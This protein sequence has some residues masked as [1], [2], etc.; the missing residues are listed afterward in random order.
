MLPIYKK[1]IHVLN[2]LPLRILSSSLQICEFDSASILC[3]I[4][5]AVS[6][7]DEVVTVSNLILDTRRRRSLISER[8][9]TSTS[10]IVR[11]YSSSSFESPDEEDEDSIADEWEV[12]D[13]E[14][15]RE[16]S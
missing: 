13:A 1:Y 2:L 7:G 12:S 11:S 10:A 8:P 14:K 4:T 9:H 15:R 5:A 16:A 3:F 6:S